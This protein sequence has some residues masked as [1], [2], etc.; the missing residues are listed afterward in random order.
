MIPK[1]IPAILMFLT[2]LAHVIGGAIDVHSPLYEA[3]GTP[4]LMAYTSIIWHMISFTIFM[5]FLALLWI[6]YY[7]NRPTALL[8]SITQIGYAILFI[9]YGI[10]HLGNIWE[11]P[12]WSIFILIPALTMWNIKKTPFA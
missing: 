10:T 7:P 3:A 8:L 2:L 9:T 6:A 4:A 5:F 12:Q 1:L 11:M